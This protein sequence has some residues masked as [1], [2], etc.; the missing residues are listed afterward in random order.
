MTFFL[1][2]NSICS[3]SIHPPSIHLSVHASVL[4][5]IYP[6]LLPSVHPQPYLYP[7]ICC[8]SVYHQSAHPRLICLSTC[9]SI[10][11]PVHQFLIRLFLSLPLQ[12]FSKYLLTTLFPQLPYGLCR[13]VPRVSH[14]LVM[15]CP[16][17]QHTSMHPCS[18]ARPVSPLGSR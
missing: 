4:L 13:K 2:V 5:S 18:E 10:H 3:T 15:N 17:P 14:C 6:S 11:P 16:F 7:S 9:L 8:P 12:S 1:P